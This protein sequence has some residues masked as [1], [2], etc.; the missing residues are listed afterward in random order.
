MSEPT[1]TSVDDTQTQGDPAQQPDD[2]QPKL[3]DAGKKAL[4]AERKAKRD[5]E[6]RAGELE[7]RLRQIEDRDKSDTQR[8]ADQLT[9]AVTRA[10]TAEHAA[11]RLRVAIA[12]GLPA[13][14]ADRLRG[15][16][17]SELEADADALLAMVA[18]KVDDAARAP[19]PRPDMSQGHGS[20]TP[21]N[22]DPLLRDLKSKLGIP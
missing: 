18:P 11:S 13:D 21:L 5:A 1:T 12:K 3:A 14:L 9:A 19:G 10:E 6:R 22:G 2:A 16:S 4:D 20:S 7:A 15:D 8:L 17:D